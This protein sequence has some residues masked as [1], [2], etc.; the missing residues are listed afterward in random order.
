MMA[1]QHQHEHDHHRAEDHAHDDHSGVG[2]ANQ[3]QSL[4]SRIGALFPFAL[5]LYSASAAS[6]PTGAVERAARAR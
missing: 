5:G 1:D 6:W 3:M 2:Q 4:C